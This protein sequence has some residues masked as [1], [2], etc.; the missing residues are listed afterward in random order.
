MKKIAILLT[1]VTHL[2]DFDFKFRTPY[3]IQIG[4]SQF[5]SL[6]SN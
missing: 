1:H 6:A 4:L 2:F 3:L 5:Y